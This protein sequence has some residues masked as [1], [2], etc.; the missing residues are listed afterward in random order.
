MEKSFIV[1]GNVIMK[2]QAYYL[3]VLIAIF[4]VAAFTLTGCRKKEQPE[5]EKQVTEKQAPTRPAAEPEAAPETAEPEE[6]AEAEPMEQIIAEFKPTEGA[7]EMVLANVNGADIT[8]ADVE[9]VMLPNLKMMASQ[10]PPEALEQYKKQQTPQVVER[11]I[12]Q[13][14][15]DQKVKQAGI[16]VSDEQVDQRIKEVA[17]R[18]NIPMDQ[19]E[20]F[21][22]TI[23]PGMEAV[24]KEIKRDL[25]YQQLMESKWEGDINVTEEEA[26]QF[27]NDNTVNFTQPEQVKARHILIGTGGVDPN[28]DPNEAR[29]EAE[30]VLQKIKEGADFAEMARKHSDDPGSAALGGELDYFSRG[31]MVPPFE[32]V[33]FS[34]EPNE[35]SGLVKTDYGYHIIQVLDHKDP[36]V[37]PFEQA[38]DRIMEYLKSTKEMEFFRNY[39][40]EIKNQADVV[41]VKP[42]AA[43]PN[44]P[45]EM[46]EAVVAPGPNDVNAIKR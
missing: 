24:R 26:L 25:S 1:K 22:N 20:Q 4:A 31:M 36:N 34:L 44:E 43:E 12:E 38:K 17:Q 21:V 45:K 40:Q 11:L 2:K 14:L 3:T 27:Y 18:H 37:V 23:G 32:E 19:Y 15:L 46:E 28:A 5:A 7:E 9:E 16:E 6:A 35:L 39:V 42:D 29:A 10:Y 41:R 33:A 30:E 8:L 13:K